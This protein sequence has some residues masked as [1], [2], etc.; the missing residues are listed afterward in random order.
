MFPPVEMPEIEVTARR[1]AYTTGPKPPEGHSM[2]GTIIEIT[3]IA[4]GIGFVPI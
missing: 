4:N 3:A 2:P 1:S